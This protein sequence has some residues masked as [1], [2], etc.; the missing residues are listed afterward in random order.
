MLRVLEQRFHSGV[1]SKSKYKIGA[2]VD[3]GS[4]S[5]EI[6]WGFW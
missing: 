3:T 5:R 4:A 2:E 1:D 6:K